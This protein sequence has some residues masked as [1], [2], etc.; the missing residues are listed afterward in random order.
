MDSRDLNAWA[1]P[2]DICSLII[3]CIE[4]DMA[5]EPFMI[6]HGIFDNRFKR[7]DLSDTKRRLGY[8]PKADAFSAWNIKLPNSSRLKE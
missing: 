2:E 8:D 4:V 7:L 5:D 3:Q 1:E 6:V